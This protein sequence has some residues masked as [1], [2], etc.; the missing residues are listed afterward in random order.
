M[1]SLAHAQTAAM[2]EAEALLGAEAT[3]SGSP[4]FTPARAVRFDPRDHV[5][6]RS[7]L[8]IDLHY[9]RATVTLPLFKGFDPDGAPVYF[10]LTEASDF[11]VA[12]RMGLNYAPKLKAAVG[13]AGAQ[14]VT[15]DGGHMHFVGRVDFSPERKV[16]PGKDYPFPPAL[17]VPGAVADARWSSIV[18]LPSG[19]VLNAQIVHNGSGDHDRLKAVDETRLRVTLSLLDGFHAGKQ[20]FYHLVTDASADVPAVIEQGVYA[21]TLGKIP[22]FGQSLRSE[23]SAL[24]GFSPVANGITDTS[25]DQFQGFGA[26]LGNGGIDPINVFPLGPDNDNRSQGNNYS[27]LWDAHVVVWTPAAYKVGKVRRITSFDDLKA[28]VRQGLIVSAAPDGPANPFVGGINP[29]RVII[30]CPVIAQPERVIR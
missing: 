25:T 3:D 14:P 7:A 13:S 30:N 2:R 11:D 21:P 8:A 26:S 12:R 20:Y 24:L 18:V 19:D 23:P 28:L 10:I 6:L 22:A 5:F 1:P 15:L 16:E 4:S 9:G 17:A 27:P 29:L